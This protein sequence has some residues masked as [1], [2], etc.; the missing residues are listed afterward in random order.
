MLPLAVNNFSAPVG[1]PVPCRAAFFNLSFTQF[2]R[3]QSGLLLMH[4]FSMRFMRI[5]MILGKSL[6]W[7]SKGTRGSRFRYFDCCCTESRK[8]KD[9]LLASLTSSLTR[10]GFLTSLG[11]RRPR[12]FR[13]A[14]GDAIC[15]CNTYPVQ[16][17]RGI[18]LRLS[19][20]SA[21]PVP[22]SIIRRRLDCH[23]SLFCGMSTCPVSEQYPVSVF[24]RLQTVHINLA[25]AVY[26]APWSSRAIELLYSRHRLR[27]RQ[28]VDVKHA[29][30]T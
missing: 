17:L 28:R 23:N 1:P 12:H 20:E 30:F 13:P 6:I 19:T 27:M 14:C 10:G 15:S 18:R 21:V 11:W 2:S 7:K 22:C 25:Q 3:R 24:G 8:T 16:D 9:S 29:V 5:G 4:T 26:I